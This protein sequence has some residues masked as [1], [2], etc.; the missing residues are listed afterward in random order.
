MTEKAI[1]Q[2]W[3]EILLAQ[4]CIAISLFF[5]W[6][7]G[8]AITYL[9]IGTNSTFSKHRKRTE[10][11]WF[12]LA[13]GFLPC[14]IVILLHHSIA[15]GKLVTTVDDLAASSIPSALILASVTFFCLL[16]RAFK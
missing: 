12:H 1:K 4:P 14:A 16:V 15:F 13:M 3:F 5:M 6:L 11:F 2:R 8:I 7:C 9:I 10:S